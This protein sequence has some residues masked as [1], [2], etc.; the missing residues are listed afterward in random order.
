M[1]FIDGLVYDGD[2]LYTGYG[3]VDDRIDAYTVDHVNIDYKGYFENGMLKGYGKLVYRGGGGHHICT[4]IFGGIE[5]FNGIWHHINTYKVNSPNYYKC[6][7]FNIFKGG[8]IFTDI[9]EEYKKHSQE[10]KDE[11]PVVLNEIMFPNYGLTDLT[12]LI[13]EWLSPNDLW[14]FG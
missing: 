11:Y 14:I 12:K 5:C 6:C 1:K 13:C 7:N 4:G 8:N 2:T 10:L 3:H 9:T